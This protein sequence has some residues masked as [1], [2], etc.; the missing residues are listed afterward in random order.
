M[1]MAKRILA[2]SV[3]ALSAFYLVC[4]FSLPAVF[5]AETAAEPVKKVQKKE[6]VY[7][8]SKGGDKYHKPSCAI[9]GNIKPENKITFKSKA[10]A[11][12]AGYKPCGICKP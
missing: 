3:V 12:K 6:M 5:A 1:N 11:E 7:V 2:G 4:S 8:A 9:V 10:A